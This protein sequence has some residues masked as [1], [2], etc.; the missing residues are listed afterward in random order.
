MAGWGGFSEQDLHRLKKDHQSEEVPEFEEKPENLRKVNIN[1]GPKRQKPR[2]KIKS[3]AT[4]TKKDPNGRQEKVLKTKTV[5]SD[6][7][8]S[9]SELNST[10]ECERSFTA[11]K[12]NETEKEDKFVVTENATKNQDEE[13][14]V[15]DIIVEPER[16]RYEHAESEFVSAK[17]DLHK[18]TERKEMLIGHL[19]AIIQQNEERKAKKLEELMAK[20]DVS[21]EVLEEERQHN[22]HDD[23]NKSV[24]KGNEMDGNMEKAD[25]HGKIT[26]SENNVKEDKSEVNE[27]SNVKEEKGQN[28]KVD[29]GNTV[30]VDNGSTI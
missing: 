6:S 30:Q 25:E 19:L 3:K 7:S 4:A 17:I 11:S 18:K 13:E 20:L 16:K 15:P 10:P 12:V 27:N 9:C 23:G 28:G 1:P 24:E 22:Q 14:K 29:H 8:V 5:E 21:E 2:E 26:E